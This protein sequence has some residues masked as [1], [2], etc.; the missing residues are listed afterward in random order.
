M[1]TDFVP[2]PPPKRRQ[3]FVQSNNNGGGQEFT[4]R[5]LD[6]ARIA[7]LT[8]ENTKLK[9]EN[10]RL[11]DYLDIT[12]NRLTKTSTLIELAFREAKQ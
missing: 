2:T 11:R 9:T 6:R 8:A 7:E 12:K 5:D 10:G 3:Q 1:I 4:Q